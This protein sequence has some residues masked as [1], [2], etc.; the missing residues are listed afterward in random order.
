MRQKLPE[1]L[2]ENGLAQS[3]WIHMMQAGETVHQV[4]LRSASARI[5][6]TSDDQMFRSRWCNSQ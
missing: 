5:C 1:F 4:K 6:L 2:N 3:V